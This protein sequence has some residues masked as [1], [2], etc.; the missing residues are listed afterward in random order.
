M[1][2]VEIDGEPQGKGRPRFRAVETK[3]GAKFVSAYTP[4][5]TRAFESAIAWAAKGAMR[6]KKPLDGPLAVTV[7]AFMGVPKSWTLKKRDA[8]LAGTIFH[9]GRPDCDNIAKGAADAMNTIVF[10][11]DS[12][13]V[14]ITVAKVY[15]KR[16]RLRIEVATCDPPL[17]A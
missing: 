3:S 15:S 2:V 16:P 9:T 10:A 6:G 8:A 14:K 17:I 11:D 1:I 5:K 4:A 13:I 12:Q 7:T